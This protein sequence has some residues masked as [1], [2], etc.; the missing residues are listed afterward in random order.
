MPESLNLEAIKARL[1]ATPSQIGQFTWQQGS[2][3]LH[4]IMTGAPAEWFYGAARADMLALIAEVE[5]DRQRLASVV[6]INDALLADIADLRKEL[7]AA[8]EPADVAS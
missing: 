6:T 2:E 4:G 3:T 8:K 1:A 7:A 5:R